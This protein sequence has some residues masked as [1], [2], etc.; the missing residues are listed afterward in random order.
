VAF[1]FSMIWL[2]AGRDAFLHERYRNRSHP[3]AH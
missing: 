3:L 1:I 2:I